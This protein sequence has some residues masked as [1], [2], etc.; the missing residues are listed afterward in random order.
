MTGRPQ[1]KERISAGDSQPEVTRLFMG[2]AD[3]GYIDSSLCAGCHQDIYAGYRHTGMARAFFRPRSE[4]TIADFTENNTFFHKAS[5]RYYAM[6]QRGDRYFQ[7]RHQIGFDGKETN[8]VEKEIHFVMGSG[9]HARTYIHRSPEGKLVGL[10][11]GWYSQKGGYWAMNPGYDRPDHKGFRGTITYECMFCHTGYPEIEPGSDKFGRDAIFKGKIP[12]GIDCQ[13]CHGPGRDHIQAAQVGATA[14]MIRRAIVNPARLSPERQLEVCMQC[15]LEST[16]F[17]LPYSA[18]RYDRAVFSYR[19]GEPLEEYVLHFDHPPGAGYDDKFEINH[20]AYRLR[21]SACF[22]RSGGSLTCTTCHNPHGVP[23]GEVAVRHYTQVC[24]TCHTAEFEKLIAAGRH[25][26]SP[27]CLRCHMPKRRT[28][29]VV[30]VVMTDHYIQR[31]TPRDNL[32]APLRERHDTPDTAY[33]GEVT[34]YYPPQLPQTAERELYLAVAQIKQHAN[35]T[36]GIPRLENAIKSIKRMQPQQGEFYFELAEG[37][38][39][40]GELDEAIAIYK[41]T[42]RRKPGFPLSLRGLEMALY[43]TGRLSEAAEVLEKMLASRPEDPTALS[44]LGLV[45]V[46]QGRPRAAVP[47]LRKA[48]RVDP[49]L[50]AAYN[51]LGLALRAVGD[52]NEAEA[53]FRNSI[54]IRP[55][56]SQAHNNLANVLAARGDSRQAEYH[57]EKAIH[58]DSKYAE[59]RY[60][61]GLILAGRGLFDRAQAQFEEA[62]R[63][64]ANFA[65]AH[66]SLGQLLAMKGEIEGAVR[67]FERAVAANPRLA[68]AHFNLGAALL[69]V[70]NRSG[71][72]QHL[73]S[74]VEHN[75]SYYEAH[76][77]LGRVLA[78]EGNHR[79]ARYHL[80]KAAQSS[81]PAIRKVALDSLEL[82]PQNPAPP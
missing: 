15:H 53:A 31:R 24:H 58:S 14:E 55:D 75:P 61:Y 78:G 16:S 73:Q 20:A 17:R 66:N 59:A 67:C 42:L 68:A 36:E 33:Q 8:V 34:L 63:L 3:V 27:E 26:S 19:P 29:D 25:S 23:R 37:Y 30:D 43:Q 6:Y 76:I 72:K 77:T 7:R 64:D 79:E 47:F 80:E 74:A 40:V 21:K 81:D 60:N 71:A 18:L 11:V 46:R 10:P 54:R 4:L 57:F 82:L 5:D 39:K 48:L 44:D 52:P 28:E 56:F 65:E 9:N 13:R 1:E 49:D 50:P 70:G 41:E 69:T 51:N 45:Y 62:V 32:L 2:G 12:E 35:L 38:R 22:Q